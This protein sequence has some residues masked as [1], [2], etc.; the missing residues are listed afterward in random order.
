MNW[1][2][3]EIIIQAEK[4]GFY[5]ITKEVETTV[6]QLAFL[7]SSDSYSLKTCEITLGNFNTV[8]AP[9]DANIRSSWT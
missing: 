6:I 5:L 3:K 8:F 9:I 1:E 7:D 2:K 4:R